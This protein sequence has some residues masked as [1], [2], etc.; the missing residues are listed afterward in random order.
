MLLKGG[1]RRLPRDLGQLAENDWPQFRDYAN[2]PSTLHSEKTQ[3][4]ERS[5]RSS[6]VAQ[7]AR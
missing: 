6:C 2:A 7:A 1:E 3:A 5:L 4:F